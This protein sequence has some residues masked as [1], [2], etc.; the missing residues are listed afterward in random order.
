MIGQ[1]LF[2]ALFA[3]IGV[4]VALI[5]RRRRQQEAA[6]AMQRRNKPD[7]QSAARAA[8]RR[9]QVRYDQAIVI[10]VQHAMQRQREQTRRNSTDG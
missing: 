8:M 6:A 7:T 1:L 3:A 4:S 5:E 10:A 9:I 2:W